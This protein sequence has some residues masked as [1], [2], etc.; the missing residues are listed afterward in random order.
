MLEIL[1]LINNFVTFRLSGNIRIW[2]V[3]FSNFLSPKCQNP[4]KFKKNLI[5]VI[6]KKLIF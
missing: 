4:K 1:F 3:C 5:I 6:K 2:T